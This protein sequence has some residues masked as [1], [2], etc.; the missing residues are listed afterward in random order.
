MTP[1]SH[2]DV[3]VSAER[4][5]GR[6]HDDSLRIVEVGMSPENCTG[7]IPGAV[8]WHTFTD[9]LNPNFSQK[10]DSA[11]MA[12]LLSRSGITPE[13][14]V[15]AYGSEPGTG[16]WIFWLLTLM[17]HRHVRVLNG[18]YRYWVK[19]G[20]PVA[21]QFSTPEP[22]TYPIAALAAD[23]Q[24]PERRIAYA[25]IRTHFQQPDRLKM[26]PVFLDVRTEREYTGKQYLIKPPEGDERAGHIPGAVH[27]DHLLTMNED[28]T[29]KP[30][31]ELKSLLIGKDVTPDRLVVPYCAVGA[32][33]AY[34]WFVL[35]HL[36]GYPTVR[37]YDGSWNEWSRLPE[38]SV[39]SFS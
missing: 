19:T 26:A 20:H 39:E 38:A 8:F 16:A 35:K 11:A 37:N 23:L 27:L 34:M 18:G 21:D 15:I 24:D 12:A 13:T 33:S 25:D 31:D 5:A 17:G 6:R 22:T 14:T 29:F 10:F 1:Y 32:R 9:L 2:P 28:G 4:L 36:L 30:F 7:H 3:L